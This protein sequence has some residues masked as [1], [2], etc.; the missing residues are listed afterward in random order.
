MFNPNDPDVVSQADT[1]A[2][3]LAD[4]ERGHRLPARA[5]ASHLNYPDRERG[6]GL[7]TVVRHTAWQDDPRL[8]AALVRSD[9]ACGI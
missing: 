1:L 3:M 6:S 2:D 9:S 8:C 5:A 7:S 4:S